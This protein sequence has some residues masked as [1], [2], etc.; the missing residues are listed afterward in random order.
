MKLITYKRLLTASLIIFNLIS[1]GSYGQ[2]TQYGQFWNEFAF[3]R[4][5]GKGWGIETNLGQTWSEGDK[6][7]IFSALAQVYARGWLH[8]YPSARWKTSLFIGYYS[9][10]EI[11]SIGQTNSNEWRWAFQGVYYFHK[12][13]YTLNS[14]TRVENRG[15]LLADDLRETVYRFREQI[16]F[17]KPLG[18]NKTIREGVPYFILSDEV[19]FKAASRASGSKFFDRNRV[20]T[21]FG[22]SITDDFQLE[23]TYANEYLPRADRNEMYHAVQVNVVVNNFLDKVKSRLEK[24]TKSTET[25]AEEDSN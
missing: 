2:T 18:G 5:I 23:L 17:V 16:K 4:S 9:N 14:R 10:S 3:T 11:E 24:L 1:V 19:M 8:Y 25:G 12:I 22:Y 7:N 15:I 6:D 20:T 21:G 13:G